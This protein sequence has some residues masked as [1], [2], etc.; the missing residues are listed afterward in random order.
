MALFYGSESLGGREI[1]RKDV[2]EAHISG[3]LFT[4]SSM[5]HLSKFSENSLFHCWFLCSCFFDSHLRVLAGHVSVLWFF[6]VYIYFHY[7]QTFSRLQTQGI[8]TKYFQ[9]DISIGP[10]QW[11]YIS[12]E[13]LWYI[14]IISIACTLNETSIP[15]SLTFRLPS[16]SSPCVLW[17][18]AYYPYVCPCP[19]VT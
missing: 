2:D 10:G 3:W 8:T 9:H 18:L 11:P 13:N 7:D 6:S 14:P 19:L 5:P 15:S 1:W 12:S 16:C 4:D 17:V